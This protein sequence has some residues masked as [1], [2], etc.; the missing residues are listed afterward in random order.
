R[1]GVA[2]LD[3]AGHG[4]LWLRLGPEGMVLR[5][6]F[7]QDRRRYWRHAGGGYAIGRPPAPDTCRVLEL[8][9]AG[10]WVMLPIIVLAVLALAVLPDRFCR[11][12]GRDA[13]PPGRGGEVR[14]WPKGRQ[15]DPRHSGALRRNSP[16][17]G[18]PAAGLDVRERPREV[19]KERIEDA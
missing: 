11:L 9:K 2:L 8:I 4:S 16:R 15:L 10:G 1:Y 12:R 19:I 17:G 18:L 5:E 7:R 3:S 14:E 13:R 6:R